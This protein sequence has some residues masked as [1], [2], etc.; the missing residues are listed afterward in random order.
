ME[1]LTTFPGEQMRSKRHPLYSQKTIKITKILAYRSFWEKLPWQNRTV[2]SRN[3]I[4]GND[5]PTAKHVGPNGAWSAPRRFFKSGPGQYGCLGLDDIPVDRHSERGGWQ[6]QNGL[7][8]N[9]KADRLLQTILRRAGR[10]PGSGPPVFCAVCVK[11]RPSPSSGP[12]HPLQSRA[13]EKLH[14]AETVRRSSCL[15]EKHER[16]RAKQQGPLP[17]YCYSAKAW[18][19]DLE[20]GKP[21]S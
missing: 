2:R 14:S 6:F 11:F 19:E 20:A 18:P 13:P 16:R 3:Q 21:S 7:P 15:F 17:N 12:A 10:K 8:R 5:L 9:R 1:R 4:T